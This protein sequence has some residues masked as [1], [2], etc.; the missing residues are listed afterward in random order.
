M[1]EL[2]LPQSEFL[3]LQRMMADVA[4]ISLADSKKAMVCGRLSS[5]VQRLRF[6]GFHEYCKHLEKDSVER[7]VAVDL[8]T[9]NETYFF[10]EPKHFDFLRT[11]VLAELKASRRHVGMDPLRL[12]SA[13][14][15]SGEEAYSLAMTCAEVLGPSSSWEVLGSD[16]STRILE[17]ARQGL[18]DMTRID[19]IPVNY[20]KAY[21][22]KGIGPQSGRILMDRSLKKKVHFH[23]VNLNV[24][25]PDIGRFDVIFMR[26][27]MIYFEQPTKSQVLQRVVGRLRAGGWLFMGHSESLNGIAHG[28][29][30]Y[31][32]SVYRKPENAYGD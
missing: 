15:S 18:Y 22:L 24:T 4:G 20:L 1:S 31:A 25:L 30:Q 3:W 17:R 19:G 12:W 8:L 16:I 13:A 6:D 29:E 21:C 2:T 23:Q 28:L 10:R 14:S 9:T 11:H 26:N 5:R 7:Q 32:P 27:V